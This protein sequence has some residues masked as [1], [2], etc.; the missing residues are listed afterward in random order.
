M[1]FK[2]RRHNSLKLRRKSRDFRS[3]KPAAHFGTTAQLWR[4]V[5]AQ[6]D[7]EIANRKIGKQV[8]RKIQPLPRPD[9]SDSRA[10][11]VH[12]P[13]PSPTGLESWVEVGSAKRF[14]DGLS[15]SRVQFTA[16]LQIRR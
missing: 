3:Q 13:D 11:S 14:R 2:E 1:H 12:P 15:S 6:Y 9:L 8:E 7:L 16:S 5:Q 4:K 10:S